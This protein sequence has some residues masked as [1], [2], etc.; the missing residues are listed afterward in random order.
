MFATS[1]LSESKKVTVFCSFFFFKKQLVVGNVGSIISNMNT[2]RADFRQ[3][4]DQ[5]KQYMIFRKVGK[6][7]EQRVITWFDYLWLQKQ[8][9]NEELIL[10]FFSFILRIY[11]KLKKNIDLFS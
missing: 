5:V 10:G 3:K 2:V 8:V 11:S 6:N 7:L 9:V 4:V 1:E